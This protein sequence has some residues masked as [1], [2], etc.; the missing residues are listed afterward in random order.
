M[1]SIIELFDKLKVGRDDFI[2]I[3]N[4]LFDILDGLED[5]K[6][7]PF[8]FSYYYL[9]DYL[10]KY[11]KYGNVILS[12]SQIKTLL[13]YS[14]T[15]K[16]I[17]KY[18][19]KNGIID[20]LNI[21]ETSK[22]VPVAVDDFNFT[23]YHELDDYHK[24]ILKKNNNY[25]IKKPLLSFMR[26]D[27]GELDG[28]YFYADNTTK[29]KFK[30]FEY[31]MMNTKLGVTS[32]YLYCLLKRYCDMYGNRYDIS[33]Y[34]LSGLSGINE[35]TLYRYLEKMSEHNLIEVHHNM[36]FYSPDHKASDRKSNSYSVYQPDQFKLKSKFNK[37]EFKRIKQDE[38]IEL[39]PEQQLDV[40]LLFS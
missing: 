24:Q 19:K 28:S 38:N 30:V 33:L 23:Y 18:M 8:C 15:Y 32:F 1:S 37:L 11:A 13:N 14:A 22:L 29:V 36:E 17:D 25:T 7:K 39:T 9:I 20:Q 16:P 21:I 27:T 34:A 40:D 26:S 12:N 4:E 31:C 2:F 6:M 3:P 5:K 35:R 10:Y